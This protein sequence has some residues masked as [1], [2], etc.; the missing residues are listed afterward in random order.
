MDADWLEAE[1]ER[2][3]HRPTAEVGIP[4]FLVP[5]DLTSQDNGRTDDAQTD[6]SLEFEQ[7]VA[8]LEER[9]GPLTAR[10]IA[11]IIEVLAE[12]RFLDRPFSSF[13]E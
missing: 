4:M 10:N 7:A 5:E 9:R 12:H 3:S 11:E 13:M 1:I 6:L 2:L 8:A